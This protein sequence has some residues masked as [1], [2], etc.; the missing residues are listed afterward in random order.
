[1]SGSR[2]QR[3]EAQSYYNFVDHVM[4]NFSLRTPG[5]TLLGQ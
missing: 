3:V 5:T 2:V 1:M 4:D